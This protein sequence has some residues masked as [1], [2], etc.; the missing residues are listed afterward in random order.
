MSKRLIRLFNTLTTLMVLYSLAGFLIVPGISLRIAN[1]QLAEVAAV[2]ATLERLQF[3]PFTL[4]LNLWGLRL[5]TPEPAIAFRHLS[6][7]AE[8]DSI[9]RQQLHFAHLAL[10]GSHVHIQLNADGSLN[11]SHLFKPSEPKASSQTKPLALRVDHFA[12]TDGQ[13]RFSD[14]RG[15]RPIALSYQDLNVELKHLNTQTAEQAALSL[16]AH[17]QEIGELRW[18]GSLAL[19]PFASSGELSVAGLNLN[20]IW[21]YVSQRV[22]L[23]LKSG[24]LSLSSQYQVRFEDDLTLK[25]D[26]LFINLQDAAIDDL[27]GKPLASLEQL[28]L[29]NS[30]VDLNQ[31]RVEL[32]T[33]DSQQLKIW[34]AREADGQINWQ[35][36]FSKAN[37]TQTGAEPQADQ[38]PWRITLN[39]A[40]LAKTH[41]YFQDQ[42]PKKPVSLELSPADFTLEQF[43]SLSD[44][45]VEVALSTKINQTANLKALG[46]IHLN[47]LTLNFDIATES[48]DTRLAQAYLEPFVKLQVRSGLLDSQ[49]KLNLASTHPLQLSVTGD[50]QLHQF[51]TLDDLRNRDLV[52]WHRLEVQGLNYQHDRQLAIAKL[53]LD[54]PYLRFIINENLTTNLSEL[55]IAQP[56]SA[57]APKSNP[58]P[59]KIGGIEIHQ[60][61]ANFAD[62]SLTPHFAT[63]IQTLNGQVSELNNQSLQP[64]R[65]N[66]QGKVDTYAPV[67]INGDLTPFDPLNQLDISASFKHME[68]TTLTPYSGK[69][70]GYRIHKGRLSLD[71][72]YQ[73]HKG[74][75]QA[76]NKV[77]LENL[78]LGEKVDSP[79]AVNLPVR[80]AIALL[81]D[82]QGNIDIAL[83]IKGDLNN[84][85][86]SVMPIVWQTLQN[87][88]LRA[89]QAPFK[90]I[91]GLVGGSS[92]DLNHIRFAPGSSQL[93][94]NASES[95]KAL[96]QALKQRPTLRLEIAGQSAAEA[97]GLLLAQERLESL[98]QQKRYQQLQEQGKKVPASANELVLS[99]KDK[100]KLTELI[101]QERF[102]QAAPSEWLALS[103]DERQTRFK[104]A[105][106]SDLASNP[107]LLRKLS[108][109]RAA[110]I[111]AYLVNEQQLA[112]ER[113]YLI[114]SAQTQA[115]QDG[116]VASLLNL[117]G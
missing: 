115:E 2:P 14:L 8:L 68:L 89:T 5:N 109:R 10:E 69:F 1:Q 55:L 65:V 105:I 43:D 34:A 17:S 42:L 32:G 71:L 26:E 64:T 6:V 92:E 37:A 45:P 7:N 36:L 18:Q 76:D 58:L 106:L 110:T 29:K 13:I 59:I 61:S 49:L 15:E 74:Q 93:D 94:E 70:A 31:Q 3:N 12:L 11:L 66:L 30:A 82:T 20:A 54:K 95:L 53:V 41:L 67:S 97:D 96:A 56:A 33:V 27:N 19:T 80:L 99:E 107:S 40:A 52:K 104:E 108:E 38:A 63:A 91:A 46:Q 39:Q 86:F 73:I 72:N 75:L 101:Y 24:L 88:V 116:W 79:D 98:Y 90:F 48:L 35:R 4:E 47:P 117:G 28:T 87:L 100:A 23:A 81:K 114:D 111:K 57:A 50:V 77:L 102:K 78:Q 16:S 62:F 22:P 25:L 51:H 85:E 83:P 60:G 103:N 9:W 84:P 113:I 21:P 112:D 44:A